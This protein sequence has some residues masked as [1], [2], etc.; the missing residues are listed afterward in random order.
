MLSKSLGRDAFERS[1]P[2]KTVRAGAWGRAR[3]APPLRAAR[4]VAVRRD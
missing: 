1:K 2:I 3:I 4:V